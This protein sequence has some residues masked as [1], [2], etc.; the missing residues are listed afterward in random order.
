MGN[1]NNKD[2]IKDSC[3]E[4]P[5]SLAEKKKLLAKLYKRNQ[6]NSKNGKRKNKDPETDFVVSLQSVRQRRSERLV[7]SIV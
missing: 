3:S 5:L 4:L 2:E 1:G 7:A 6:H